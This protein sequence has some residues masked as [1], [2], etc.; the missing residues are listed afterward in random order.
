LY[1]SIPLVETVYYSIEEGRRVYPPNADSIG[2]PLYLV[3]MGLLLLSPVY[4]ALVWAATRFYQGGRSLLAFDINRPMRSVFWSLL[5][6]GLALFELY[7]AAYSVCRLVP[8]DVGAD[9][10]WAY[11]L[12][13]LRSSLAGDGGRQAEQQRA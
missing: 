7:E 1:L 10:L 2:I 5:L 8:M 11:L 9:L 13:C 3:T 12:L 4:V 6:G